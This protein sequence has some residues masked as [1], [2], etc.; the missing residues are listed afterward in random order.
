MN[1]LARRDLT[2][3][4][5][6]ALLRLFRTGHS[7]LRDVRTT[8]PAAAVGAV[9]EFGRDDAVLPAYLGTISSGFTRW[10]VEIQVGRWFPVAVAV[11]LYLVLL[12]VG[13]RI[14]KPESVGDKTRRRARTMSMWTTAGG[15]A[16]AL[17]VLNAGPGG[18]WT[19]FLPL[20]AATVL[21]GA[22]RLRR[23]KCRVSAWQRTRCGFRLSL[24]PRA[25]VFR[26]QILPSC[27]TVDAFVDSRDTFLELGDLT[28]AAWCVAR[29]A[30]YALCLGDVD[31]A[32]R[33]VDEPGLA[34]HR[35]VVSTK[36]V[37]LLATGRQAPAL[38]ILNSIRADAGWRTPSRLRDQIAMIEP[39]Q[40]DDTRRDRRR[41]RRMVWRR[42]YDEIAKWVLLDTV[43]H[44][45]ID[46]T[47]AMA[48]A[49]RVEQDCAAVSTEFA[50]DVDLV[51]S[52]GL[53]HARVD[54]RR[55]QGD[56]DAA[57]SRHE[58][59]VDAYQRAYQGYLA[60]EDH[61]A[62]AECMVLSAVEAT[63]A[64]RADIAHQLDT[65]HSGLRLIAPNRSQ[66]HNSL[67]AD[68]FDTVVRYMS[69][70]E[71]ELAGQVCLWLLASRR[72]DA[73]TGEFG[74]IDLDATLDRTGG[75]CALVYDATEEPDGWTFRTVTVSTLA[76]ITAHTARLY[77]PS[78]EMADAVLPPTTVEV[79]RRHAARQSDPVLLVV[80]DGPIAEVAFPALRLPDGSRVIDHVRVS[81]TPSLTPR[82][83]AGSDA[84]ST[85]VP[86]GTAKF[87]PAPGPPIGERVQEA[88][89]YAVTTL[90]RTCVTT[91]DFVGAASVVDYG[92]SSNWTAFAVR[93]G[94]GEQPAP[95]WPG[96]E[97]A[98]ALTELSLDGER[99]LVSTRL[100]R[101]VVLGGRLARHRGE[102]VIAPRHLVYGI[103][104]DSACDGAR[105]LGSGIERLSP[106]ALLS[107][108]GDRLFSADLPDPTTVGLRDS[109]SGDPPTGPAPVRTRH[110]PLLARAESIEVRTR[111]RRWA[112]G[113]VVLLVLSLSGY[114]MTLAKARDRLHEEAFLGVR[115]S[116]TTEANGVALTSIVG[117][118]THSPAASAGLRDGDVV[119]DIGGLSGPAP[120]DIT[121]MVRGH[122]PG[123]VLTM[124]I[125]R[126]EVDL[127][128]SVVLAES[129]GEQQ[130]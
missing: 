22:V 26:Y 16:V 108:L 42:Q 64:G 29:A 39:R 8:V 87:L 37:L 55:I 123:D 3:Y 72:D 93:C 105:W 102:Q 1:S 79:L 4:L 43:A 126:G 56:C 76:G 23:R 48:I 81:I 99:F 112:T 124:T 100:A 77:G 75:Q 106:T 129:V 9:W 101:A 103:L 47:A 28:S 125:R 59:A 71:P 46:E 10:L 41:Y 68:V 107:T 33:L 17:D 54:A 65:I 73:S 6:P 78:R 53:R 74:A 97:S 88:L 25:I 90:R 57:L 120:S 94:V 51:R 12:H 82:P 115:M 13:A 20:I 45:R 50:Y 18:F 60:L 83:R 119:L 113:V 114:V 5:D 91:L 118:F 40:S 96:G 127:K 69:L 44:R 122:H 19:R 30:E 98:E 130:P 70:A 85:P 66:R 80:P 116:A 61:V 2:G 84:T 128:V 36:A 35:T 34:D 62:A 11:L 15:F 7:V 95:S 52:V 92:R 14:P 49:A 117:V 121:A 38:T 32:Q 21:A 63:K 111:T 58:A 86:D 27:G 109:G 31:T 67:Y 104:A 110:R 24:R 89:R